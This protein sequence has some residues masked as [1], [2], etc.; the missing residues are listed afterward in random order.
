[1][2]SNKTR[3]YFPVRVFFTT[4]LAHLFLIGMT[5]SAF[6]EEAK[7]S[8]YWV[9]SAFIYNI[10]KFVDE[11]ED[12][13]GN[14]QFCVMGEAP[15]I[16]DFDHIKNKLVNGKKIVIRQIQDPNT[17]NCK[18][19]FITSSERTRISQITG[20][21]KQSGILT[22]SDTSGFGKKGVMVNFFL[23]QNKIRF[24]INLGA[25][26]ESGVKISSQLLN[27]STIVHSEP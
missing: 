24:E 20:Q 16:S 8:E 13:S 7:N 27:L 10:F 9:K 23:D 11:K 1:M 18:A 6:S 25:A 4:L 12:N 15:F 21:L 5:S 2:N 17:P 3:F 26:E 14:Y 19:I 22:I